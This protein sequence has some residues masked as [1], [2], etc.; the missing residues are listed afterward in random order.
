MDAT[1]ARTTLNWD[2]GLS[3]LMRPHKMNDC[4]VITSKQAC[5]STGWSGQ[6]V[7]QHGT[8]Q[9][10]PSASIQYTKPPRSFQPSPSPTRGWGEWSRL[11]RVKHEM[12]VSGA[13]IWKCLAV[14]KNGTEPFL[15]HI[16]CIIE[17]ETLKLPF[18]FRYPPVF[19]TSVS[20]GCC[21]VT[22]LAAFVCILEFHI[23][24]KNKF[25]N[26][27]FQHCSPALLC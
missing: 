9:A 3:S 16:K 19:W 5:L 4:I 14:E 10:S 17:N 12:T 6:Q 1:Y 8:Q 21:F 20:L 15:S 23:G 24:L 27:P 22:L 26:V 11:Q 7:L 25:S 2:R 13:I 18:I